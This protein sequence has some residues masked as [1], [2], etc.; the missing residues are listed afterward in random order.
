M[1]KKIDT[2][3]QLKIFEPVFKTNLE[4]YYNCTFQEALDRFSMFNNKW[5]I[6]N[7]R[8][9]ELGDCLG[10]KYIYQE[11]YNRNFI[12]VKDITNL[13]PLVHELAHL[14]FNILNLINLDTDLENDEVFAYLQEYFY[15]EVIKQLKWK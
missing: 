7:R 14:V 4:L 11:G 9:E 15:N 12:W 13:G 10:W 3:V 1:K 6:T 2:L 5:N 8:N